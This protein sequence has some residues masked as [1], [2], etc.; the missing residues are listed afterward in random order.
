M[1]LLPVRCTLGKLGNLSW[2][3]YAARPSAPTGAK[4]H[5]MMFKAPSPFPHC[6]LL[7]TITQRA[8]MIHQG[9]E[10]HV[11]PLATTHMARQKSP[12][13]EDVE[14]KPCGL[15]RSQG[16]CHISG[17]SSVFCNTFIHVLDYLEISTLGSASLA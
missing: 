15:R 8:P 6:I 10:R 9:E 4:W 14:P 16:C 2:K 17:H 13:E 12:K 11:L 5:M 7:K 3:S 1:I